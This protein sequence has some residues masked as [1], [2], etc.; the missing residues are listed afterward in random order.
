MRLAF[1]WISMLKSPFVIYS[2][3]SNKGNRQ[4]LVSINSLD[5]DES[6]LLSQMFTGGQWESF[7]K[8]K[9]KF[10]VRIFMIVSIA[11][12]KTITEVKKRDRIQIEWPWS[13]EELN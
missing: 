11:F 13:N 6:S 4:H 1:C 9:T 5:F 3:D 8:K 10:K 7:G 2:L 12:V